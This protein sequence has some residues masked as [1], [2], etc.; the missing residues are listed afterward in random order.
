MAFAALAD[1]SVPVE[2]MSSWGF[3][4]EGDFTVLEMEGSH[5]YL[6][7]SKTKGPF[8]KTLLEVV[9]QLI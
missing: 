1:K 9:D 5:F 7:D 8:E 4:T 2:T 3:Y 6:T